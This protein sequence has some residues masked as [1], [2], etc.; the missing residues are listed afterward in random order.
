MSTGRWTVWFLSSPPGSFL[1]LLRALLLTLI[2][3][4]N[5]MGG[6]AETSPPHPGLVLIKGSETIQPWI[7]MCAE[8]FM[9][10]HPHRD[11]VVQGG[12]SGTGIAALFHGTVDIGMVSRDLTDK[13]REHA[14]S[15]SFHLR[16][17]AVAL[18]GI[19]IV[20]HPDNPLKQISLDRLRQIFAGQV[21]SWQEVGG[22][23]H[24]MVVLARMAGSGTSALFR[25]RVLAGEDYAESVQRMPTNTAI[26]TKVANHPA[27]IGYSGLEA[28]QAA[29][30]Q[31]KMVALQAAPASFPVLPE[32]ETIRSG[33][34]PLA[35][36]LHL[37][38]AGEPSGPVK[39]F[40]DFCLSSHSQ[41]L[42][43]KAGFIT[44]AH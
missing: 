5:G 12:G 36:T 28:V 2:F 43:R 11:V 10:K 44:I 3:A 19:A 41:E 24:D 30:G 6:C 38:T 37:Y 27:A 42:V 33:R 21:R 26:I 20:V 34:Y 17:Y 16:E 15:T 25:Q 29:R 9:S 7:T 32:V 31:V 14:A 39:D 18:D 13:E 22:T 40:L 1:S 23:Q 35:R 8:D 4:M